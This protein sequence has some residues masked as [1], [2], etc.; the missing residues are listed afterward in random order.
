M[1]GTY[2]KYFFQNSFDPR[3]DTLGDDF[4]FGFSRYFVMYIR[5][6][7]DHSAESTNCP[8]LS[9]FLPFPPSSFI[10]CICLCAR[11]MWETDGSRADWTA[12]AKSEPQMNFYIFGGEKEG[13]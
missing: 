4:A 8:V 3:L 2:S 11:Q 10:F 13:S 5:F 6:G 7:F 12:E 1:Y 9:L